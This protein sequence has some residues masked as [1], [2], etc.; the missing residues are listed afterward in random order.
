MN[1]TL[2]TISAFII[3]DSEGHRVLAKYYRP[4]SAEALAPLGA[5]G[6]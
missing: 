4:K 3:M 5:K 1:L 6:V 2:Y